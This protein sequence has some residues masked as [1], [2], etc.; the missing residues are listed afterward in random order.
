M[1]K[2]VLRRILVFIPTLIAITL[3]GFVIMV[4][5]PGDPVE[6]MVVAAQ[7]GGEIGT[8]SANQLQ[9]KKFWSK[10]LGLDLPIFYVSLN[11]LAQS[12][13]L[14][15]I[16]DK[17]ERAALER[18]TDTYGNWPAISAYYAAV[19]ELNAAHVG[20]AI[21]SSMAFGH[22]LTDVKKTLNSSYF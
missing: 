10:K 5:A 15:R 14:Y 19:S 7:S 2:Y 20:Y 3:L 21:D 1:L 8:Q 9:Q 13:T 17:N 18:L 11:S 4:S 12:D 6:R 22:P 16:Y